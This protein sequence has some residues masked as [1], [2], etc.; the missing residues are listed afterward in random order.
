M[1]EI[2]IDTLAGL[3]CD[4]TNQKNRFLPI[5]WSTLMYPAYCLKLMG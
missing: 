3:R 1:S 4:V 2:D 5:F